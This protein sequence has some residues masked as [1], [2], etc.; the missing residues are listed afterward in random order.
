M[1]PEFFG[2]L[3]SEIFLLIRVE[4]AFHLFCYMLSLV[5]IPHVKVDLHIPDLV[6]VS[7]ARAQFPL[8]EPVNIGKFFAHGTTDDNVHQYEVMR[9]RIL[10]TYLKNPVTLEGIL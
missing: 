4:M 9:V 10:K 1:V 6:R 8:L 5:M 3:E 7:A 2:L